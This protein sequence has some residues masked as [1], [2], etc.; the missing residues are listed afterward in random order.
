MKSTHKHTK[1][2]LIRFNN[3]RSLSQS[4]DSVQYLFM[5]VKRGQL[6]IRQENTKSLRNEKR[7]LLP[8]K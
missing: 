7:K 6:D 4:E 1:A 8:K 2:Q 3:H 5:D